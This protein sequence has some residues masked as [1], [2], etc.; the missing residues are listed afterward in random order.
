MGFRQEIDE[1]IKREELAKQRRNERADYIEKY[2]GDRITEEDRIELDKIRN[3]DDYDDS[4]F[5][6]RFR[7]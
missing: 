3:P 2:L 7:D 6:R 4:G 5:R 1:Q